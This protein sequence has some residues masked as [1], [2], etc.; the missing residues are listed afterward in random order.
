MS[1][2][3]KWFYDSVEDGNR[4]LRG[5]VVIYKDDPVIISQIVG[6]N[7]D[8]H[9]NFYRIPTK[10][11]VVEIDIFNARNFRIRDLPTLG[12]VDWKKHSYYVSRVS[13]RQN[14][15]GISRHNTL[16]QTNPD[17]G[18]P[19]LDH[20]IQTKSFVDMLTGRYDRFQNVFDE[21]VASEDPIKKSFGKTFALSVDDMETIDLEYRGMKVARVNNPKRNG[22]RFSL[23]NKFAFLKEELEENG[24]RVEV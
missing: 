13:S 18:T 9:A 12:Y 22:P 21:L 17:G 20:L 23:P 16:I 8:Q 4:R 11:P 10:N 7:T 19:T 2:N 1:G 24:I 5:S 14:V 3:R 15:Q 6:L